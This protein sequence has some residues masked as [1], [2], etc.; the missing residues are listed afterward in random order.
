[1]LEHNGLSADHAG[2][3]ELDRVAQRGRLAVHFA[4]DGSARLQADAPGHDGALAKLLIPVAESAADGSW[5][6]VKACRAGDCQWAFYD[7]SRNRSGVW[8]D[9]AVCGNRTKVRA[10]RARG[11]TDRRSQTAPGIDPARYS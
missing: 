6:R 10:Y 8:C 4:A 11:S 7:N 9:M 5:Q 1:M 3:G 2:G